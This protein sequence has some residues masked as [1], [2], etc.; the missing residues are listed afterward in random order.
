M[1]RAQRWARLE[2]ELADEAGRVFLV[3]LVRR[4]LTMPD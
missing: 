2:S 4:E 1:K 3:V